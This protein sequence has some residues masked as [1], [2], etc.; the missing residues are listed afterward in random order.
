MSFVRSAPA[1]ARGLALSSGGSKGRVGGGGAFVLHR[2]SAQP[3]AGVAKEN[4]TATPDVPE[5]TRGFGAF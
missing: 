2:F 1:L 4:K 5:L 3:G